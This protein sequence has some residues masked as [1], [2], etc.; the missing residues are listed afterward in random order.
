MLKNKS[1]RAQV[2]RLKKDMREVKERV[3]LLMLDAD[4]AVNHANHLKDVHNLVED[5][6]HV[7]EGRVDVLE[8]CVGPDDKSDDESDVSKPEVAGDVGMEHQDAGNSK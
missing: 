8:V 3:R 4:S 2:R 5:K 1:L 7:L 6:V